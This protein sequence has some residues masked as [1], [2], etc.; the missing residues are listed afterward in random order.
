M[1][2]KIGF[3][4]LTSEIH[5]SASIWPIDFQRAALLSTLL[6][7]VSMTVWA[8]Q[9][10]FQS[11]NNISSNS[12]KGHKVKV[13]QRSKWDILCYVFVACEVV[14]TII[15][16][17]AS[18]FMSAFMKQ[19]SSGFHLNN[20]TLDNFILVI[21]GNGGIALFNSI[22][23]A[24]ISA[25]LA[26]VIGLWVVLITRKRHRLG[27][28]IDFSSLLPNTVPGIIVVIGLILFWN[29]KFNPLPIYNTISI[30][31]VAYTVLYI[32]YAV[33]NIRTVDQQLSKNLIEAAEISGS[34]GWTLFRT[35]TLPLLRPGIFSGWIL[36]F[37]I[38][39]RELVAS[40]MLRPPNTDTS[41]TFIYRQFEQGD[42]AQGMAMALLSIGI[43][44][45][46]LII[47][48]TYQRK[49]RFKAKVVVRGA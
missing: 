44:S 3:Q 23:L 40:L 46:I 8:L 17:Y 14:V 37:C 45:I 27:R 21:S 6:L 26:S 9:Q 24:T 19:L 5:H 10:W 32:P 11:R 49:K 36:I 33:Q 2:N 42:S 25:T 31:V 15:L 1:G 41:S 4:V 34:K 35:I 22:M 48:E 13:H 18:I 43:T 30:L 20:F 16:P 29:N 39:M 28:L 12:G 7:A 47:L 38:S